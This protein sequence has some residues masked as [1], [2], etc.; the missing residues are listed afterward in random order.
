MRILFIH[1]NFPGQ[2][3]HLALALKADGH[4]V[5]ALA[6]GGAGLPAIPMTRHQT[7]TPPSGGSGAPWLKEFESKVLR[8][9]SA[10]GAMVALD[11]NGWHP[12]L[13]VAHPSW[14]EALFV[15]DLWPR[16]KLLCYLE[17]FYASEGRDVGFDPEF[18]QP[19]LGVRSQLR[20]KNAVHLLALE[21]MD[22]GLAPTQWQRA[23]FPGS[24][25]ANIEV[26]FDGID[27]ARVRPN[28]AAEVVLRS[29]SGQERRLKAGDEVLTFVS[30]QLEPYR[31]YHQFMR[32]LPAVL[33]ARPQAVAVIVGGSKVSY[34]PAAPNGQSWRDIFLQE[35]QPQLDMERVFFLGQVEYERYLQLLQVSACHVYLTYPFVLSWSCVEALAAGCLVVGSRT[36][37]VQEF[38]EHQ[39]NG[40]LVDFFQPDALAAQV[41]EA[42]SH[43]E[44]H[45]PLRQRAREWAV[46]RHDLRQHALPGQRAVIE[47]LMG[48]MA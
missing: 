37:P 6:M 11:Q 43:P 24:A 8:G 1:Q 14:G 13:V 10:L 20:L 18:G 29:A 17:F 48:G 45:A 3:R 42:L 22:L 9:A 2:F 12:D 35:V 26:V 19:D 15:K 27:T 25:Q 31:G 7:Q 44:R 23:S 46:E 36:A 47:R 33:K 34:G 16:A 4:D 40:L 21:A 32:A 41:V 30:R 5:R 38:I 39:K 28:A